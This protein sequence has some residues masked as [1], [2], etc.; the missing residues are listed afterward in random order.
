MASLVSWRRGNSMKR[1]TTL[2]R[3]DEKALQLIVIGMSLPIR[4]DGR[5]SSR[6]IEKNEAQDENSAGL[7]LFD[8]R[9]NN[10]AAKSLD[11]ARHSAMVR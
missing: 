11:P 10:G 9:S 5:P 6:S 3:A 4:E 1:A 7:F 8:L 2:R